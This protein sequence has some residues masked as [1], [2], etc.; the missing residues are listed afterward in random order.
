MLAKI[1]ALLEHH[2]EAIEAA[3]KARRILI[4]IQ[5]DGVILQEMSSLMTISNNELANLEPIFEDY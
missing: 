5:P 1:A 3:D 2:Q 4:Y